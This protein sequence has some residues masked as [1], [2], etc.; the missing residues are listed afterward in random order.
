MPL[1]AVGQMR[2]T[3]SMAANLKQAQALVRK[4][5]EAGAKALFLPEAADYITTSGGLKLC[6]PVTESEFVL[7]LQRSAKQYSLA[8][9]VGIHE[10]ATN[11]SANKV[12]NSLIWIDAAGQI[13]HRYQKLHLFD[14]HVQGGGPQMKESDGVEPGLHLP[15][16]FPSPV[17]NLGMQICFDLRFPEPALALRSRGAHVLL[18]PAAFTTPTGRAGHW[19]VLLRARAIETQSWVVAAAQVGVHDEQGKRRSWGHSMI[20]DPWGKIVAELGGDGGEGASWEGEGEIAVAE[21]D[22]EYVDKVRRE[23]GLTRRTDVYAELAVRFY[24][25][26]NTL[27]ILPPDQPRLP[28]QTQ[29]RKPMPLTLNIPLHP[30][31]HLP[32]PTPPQLRHALQQHGKSR[33]PHTLPPRPLRPRRLELALAGPPAR[34]LPVMRPVLMVK[35]QEGGFRTRPIVAQQ[36]V[37]DE[38]RTQTQG[39]FREAEFQLAAERNLVRVHEAAVCA[40]VYPA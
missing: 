18:Y 1:A 11:A 33:P 38:F 15:H 20:V 25:P 34:P 7:G 12:K 29:P 14:M 16:P 40:L 35:V 21:I 23:S 4:A 36:R 9:S 6:K 3:A 8:I 13:T 31:P 17:G 26:I 32:Q 30:R 39:R 24:P 10:P 28:P 19:E 2:S 27:Q 5:H 37:C 22:L